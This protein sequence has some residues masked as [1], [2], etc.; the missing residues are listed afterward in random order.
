MIIVIENVFFEGLDII[1]YY[2]F[3]KIVIEF[4][5]CRDFMNVMSVVRVLVIN[6]ILFLF[7]YFMDLFFRI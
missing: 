3:L 6:Y 2:K 1:K 5:V 7:L 4:V